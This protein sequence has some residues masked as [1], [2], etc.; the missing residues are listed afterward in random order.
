MSCWQRRRRRSSHSIAC[1]A[2]YMFD[3]I[4]FIT[5]LTSTYQISHTTCPSQST[6]PLSSP[7]TIKQNGS[8]HPLSHTQCAPSHSHQG[9]VTITIKPEKTRAQLSTSARRQGCYN[10]TCTSVLDMSITT[11]HSPTTR[12]R[13]LHPRGPRTGG[14]RCLR[15]LAREMVTV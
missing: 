6:S 14:I 5:P 12:D 3:E 2:L 10:R 7:S 15:V 1:I 4:E 11:L 8:L 13:R 9:T